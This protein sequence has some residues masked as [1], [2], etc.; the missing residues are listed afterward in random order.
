M[1]QVPKMRGGT[2]AP[3]LPPRK[4]LL[5]PPD[6]FDVVDEKNVHMKG[7]QGRV[8]KAL[9]K[10][11]WQILHDTC[12]ALVTDGNLEEVALVQPTPGCED[13]VFCA[14]PALPWRDENGEL[15][16]ILSRMLHPS[17]QKE[18]AAFEQFFEDR[19]YE[20]LR[21][22]SKGIFEGMGD[23]IL[24]PTLPMLFGG[25]GFRTTPQAYDEIHEL[26]GT[27]IMLMEMTNPNFYHLDTCLLPM[28]DDVCLVAPD[29]FSRN[30]LGQLRELFY[31]VIEVPG[32]EAMQLSLNAMVVF[33]S[34]PVAILQQGC[35][36]TVAVMKD[37][38]CQVIEIDTSEY[39]KSGGSVFCMKLMF[40]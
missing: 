22:G 33:G 24:H 7:Q 3:M 8:D 29:A 5:C 1:D 17:R 14:N 34:Q 10:K 12:L 11:Q 13:M 19:G 38:G 23:C 26:L 15:R 35:P 37:A 9:A 32:E 25:H 36:E 2:F 16:V 31:D 4:V 40:W 6:H 18:V 30:S 28:T 20:I 21:L 27:E 39:L